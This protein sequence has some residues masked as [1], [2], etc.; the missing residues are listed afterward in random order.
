M[1]RIIVERSL[2]DAPDFETVQAMEDAVAWCL[3][4][5]RV[6]FIRSYF[7]SDK[8]TMICEYEAPD[9]ESVRIVQRTGKLPFE[10]IWAA[11]VFEWAEDASSED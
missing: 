4:E 10:R 2:A 1:S 6:E 7:S 5:H 3:E 11:Q 8:K 9:A